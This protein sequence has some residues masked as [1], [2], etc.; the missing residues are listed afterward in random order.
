MSARWGPR[1]LSG[2]RQMRVYRSGIRQ[3]PRLANGILANSTT[4]GQ[5]LSAC[6]LNNAKKSVVSS[7][8]IN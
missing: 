4:A 1:L 7:G 6:R 3:N 5:N 8:Q 2:E